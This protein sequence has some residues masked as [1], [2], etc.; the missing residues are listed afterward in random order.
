LLEQLGVAPELVEKM[1]EDD[2]GGE[3]EVSSRIERR[4]SPQG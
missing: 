3:E 2:E 1:G 4:G